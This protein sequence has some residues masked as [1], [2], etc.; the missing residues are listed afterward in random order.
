[1]KE[2]KATDK[3]ELFCTECGEPYYPRRCDVPKRKTTLCRSCMLR[4]RNQSAKMRRI[5]SEVAK[6]PKSQR[7]RDKLKNAQLAFWTE[8]QRKKR[9]GKLNPVWR[10]GITL[11]GSGYVYIRCKGH[12][13]AKQ[14]GYYVLEH[15]LVMEEYLGRYLEDWEIV[16]HKN[17]D[18]TDNRI[19][20]LEIMTQSEHVKLH[21]KLRQE[22]SNA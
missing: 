13:K 20:N 12:P 10:D 17:G 22:V 14:K 1:M 9:R 15:R 11:S 7:T 5:A 6:Q 16:H 19:E 21:H 4:N 2:G 8:E 18:I 3:V